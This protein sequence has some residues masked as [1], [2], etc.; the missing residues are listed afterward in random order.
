MT[1]LDL[2]AFARF[3]VLRQ[4][5]ERTTIADIMERLQLRPPNIERSV[6]ALSG[7]NR[8]KSDAGTRAH[9]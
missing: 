6:G 7:G 2:P 5:A 3:G 8:R 4:A 9:A 1:V